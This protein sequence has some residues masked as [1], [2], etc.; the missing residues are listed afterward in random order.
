MP[1]NLAKNIKYLRKQ[2]AI[3]QAQLAETVHK[4]QSSVAAWETNVSEPGISE[5]LIMCDFFKVSLDELIA[6]DLSEI[7]FPDKID[8]EKPE[9][10]QP[11]DQGR[12]Y[13]AI[14]G[15][16]LRNILDKSNVVPSLFAR[17]LGVSDQN[18]QGK[19]N[20]L[21]ITTGTLAKAAKILHTTPPELWSKIKGVNP[22]STTKH[23]YTLN[24]PDTATIQQR[25]ILTLEENAALY[26]ELNRL[27]ETDKG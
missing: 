27:K 12:N 13:S 17:Y 19:F 24:E 15:E 21:D 22:Y 6:Q 20:S 7:V 4:K 8:I 2:A 25:Y 1:N 26:K 16:E 11:D 9:P 18:V 10:N 5:L 14:T 23:L 3:N